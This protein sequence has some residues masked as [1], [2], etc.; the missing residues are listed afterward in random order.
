MP[1]APLAATLPPLRGRVQRDVALAPFT[2]FRVGGPADALVRPADVD[3]LLVLLR[4]MPADMPLTILGA[5]SNLL[6]RDGGIRGVTLRL[7]RG[8][9]AIKLD[10]EGIIA[11]AG[12]LDVTLAETAAAAGL[13]GLEFLVGIPGTVGGAVAM[14]AG[15]YGGEIRDVLDWAEVATPD[16]LLRLDAA[17]LHLAYR[18]A[19]LPLRGL[20]FVITGG[21][22]TFTRDSIAE[23]I[24]AHGGK[25]ASAVSKKTDYLLVGSDPGSKLAKAQEL[26]VAVIDEA[27]FKVLLSGR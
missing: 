11:G 9:S 6:I 18:H 13:A 14:N 16:G 12:V 7:A 25:A 10:G 26:G 3:D 8:F 20:T 4:D 24:A 22:E 2:W 27:G 23:T 5:A 1:R 19:S 17:A 21:L 15:A